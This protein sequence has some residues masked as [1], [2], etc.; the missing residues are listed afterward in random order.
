MPCPPRP[1][2]ARSAQFVTTSLFHEE[3]SDL[4]WSG[5]EIVTTFE[6][7]ADT[8]GDGH[9]DLMVS[10]TTYEGHRGEEDTSIRES[11][12]RRQTTCLYEPANDWWRCPETLG[13]K[14]LDAVWLALPGSMKSN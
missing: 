2:R 12:S 3:W 6:A 9:L 10:E 1:P 11:E 7:K 8:N 13:A 14:Y 4:S 5:T